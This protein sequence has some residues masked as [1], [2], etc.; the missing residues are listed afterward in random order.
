MKAVCDWCQTFVKVH[1]TFDPLR[2]AVV[3]SRGCEDAET[4]FRLW[5]SDEEINRRQHYEY[6]TQ[7][8]LDD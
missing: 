5:M 2:D 6:L 3:C 8:D 7:G 1:D 4:I